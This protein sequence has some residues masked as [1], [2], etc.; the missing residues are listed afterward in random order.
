M[1]KVLNNI[2]QLIATNQIKMIPRWQFVL[3][4]SLLSIVG[5]LVLL[6]IVYALS[7]FVFLIRRD[8]PPTNA[9]HD[10]LFNLNVMP[11]VIVLFSIV[12]IVLIEI[13]TKKYTFAYRVPSI[14]LF[15]IIIT[16][17]SAVSTFVDRIMFHDHMHKMFL[18]N[19]MDT[20]DFIY[21]RPTFRNRQNNIMNMIEMRSEIF[22]R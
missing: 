6:F 10:I 22:V 9:M 2:N 3:R 5:F 1:N 11:V 16:F 13:L 4:T 18:N 21:E 7:L 15:L 8:A 14:V 12:G 17:V 20:L 19:K